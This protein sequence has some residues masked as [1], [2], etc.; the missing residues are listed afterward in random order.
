MMQTLGGPGATLG[1][2][3]LDF[4]GRLDPHMTPF[5]PPLGG[6]EDAQ[7][8]PVSGQISEESLKKAYKG[9]PAKSASYRTSNRKSR[10]A[11]HA[12]KA[13]PGKKDKGNGFATTLEG[14]D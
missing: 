8:E 9:V 7:P 12:P 5:G 14:L 13:V 3:P 1:G 10:S 11:P 6:P 4:G 2:E